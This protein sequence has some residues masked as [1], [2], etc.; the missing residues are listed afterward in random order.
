MP[1]TD[2]SRR[3]LHMRVL[4]GVA[5]LLLACAAGSGAAGAVAAKD[6]SPV[7]P[8]LESQLSRLTELLKD[9]DASAYRAATMIQR[10]RISN[11]HEI[12]LAV[13]SV[14]GFE[15]GNNFTQYLAAFA[16]MRMKNGE[17]GYTLIDVLPIGASGWRFVRALDAQLIS[18]APGSREQWAYR[19]L[20]LDAD[21]SL[22]ALERRPDDS[23]NNPTRPVKLL[24]AIRN[25]RLALARPASK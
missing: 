22:D 15:G 12:V 21:L 24:L 18:T 23:I 5:F 1:G 13:F 16:P 7:P 11:E 17:Q 2:A 25:G 19:P 10:V 8:A 14:E 3:W 20:E 6:P 9:A 4:A